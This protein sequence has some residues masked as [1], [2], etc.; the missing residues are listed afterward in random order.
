MSE[1]NKRIVKEV[2][3]AFARNDMEG[4]LK[5]CA[6]DVVWHMAGDRTVSGRDN[7]REWMQ[8]MEGHGPPKFTVDEIIAEGDSAACRG[9]MTMA[10]PDGT[11]NNYSYCDVYNFSGG[12]ITK[13]SAYVVQEKGAAEDQKSAGA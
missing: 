12:K 13:L 6:D 10:G 7:I 4:F 5:Y 1:E 8:Q 2:N 11:E 9:E 3:D